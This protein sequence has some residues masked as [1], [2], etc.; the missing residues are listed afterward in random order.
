MTGG[1]NSKATT[2]PVQA[3]VTALWLVKCVYVVK[4]ESN[5]LID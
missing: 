2:T 4:R 5:D 1:K 3:A